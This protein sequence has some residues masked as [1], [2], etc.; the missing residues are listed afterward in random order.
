M[1][2]DLAAY[3]SGS[4]RNIMAKAYRNVLTNP[5][6]AKFVFR[7]QRLFEKSERRRKKVKEQEGVLN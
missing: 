3:M 4:I 6:E 2:M 5:C 1:T 7:M